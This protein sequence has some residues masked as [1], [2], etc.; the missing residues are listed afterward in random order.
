[1]EKTGKKYIIKI[2]GKEKEA[3]QYADEYLKEDI[4]EV[5]GKIIFGNF[6]IVRELK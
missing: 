2:G 4:M 3:I 5:D 6:E 1:M